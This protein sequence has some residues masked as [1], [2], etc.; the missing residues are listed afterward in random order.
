[1]IDSI[2]FSA[3]SETSAVSDRACSASVLTAFSTASRARSLFG[4]NSFLSSEENSVTSIVAPAACCW[5]SFL[6]SAMACYSP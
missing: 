5:A 6:G 3:S 2:V 1:M 4:L